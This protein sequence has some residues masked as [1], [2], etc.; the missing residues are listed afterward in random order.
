MKNPL[1]GGFGEHRR[2]GAPGRYFP[3][4]KRLNITPSKSSGVNRPVMLDS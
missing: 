1:W 2:L 4:Q 3:I